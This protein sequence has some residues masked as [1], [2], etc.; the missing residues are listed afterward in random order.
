MG[1]GNSGGEARKDALKI[2]AEQVWSGISVLDSSIYRQSESV[3]NRRRS[4]E[5]EEKVR[6]DVLKSSL[7][8][9]SLKTFGQNTIKNKVNVPAY[10]CKSDVA[11][12]YLD[13]LKSINQRV[14]VQKVNNSFC[15]ALYNTYSP[16][17]MMFE[18][19]LKRLGE[20]GKVKMTDY[21]I[22]EKKCNEMS[23]SMQKGYV[24]F[25][26]AIDRAVAEIV[27]KRGKAQTKI[28]IAEIYAPPDQLS[29][30][31]TDEL[32]NKLVK[33]KNFA[34]MSADMNAI[35]GQRIGPLKDAEAVKV[36]KKANIVLVGRF[37]PYE[38][39]SHFKIEALD[40]QSPPPPKTLAMH[41]DKIR[42]D[43]A[44]LA[45][46]ISGKPPAITED[47]LAYLN[48]GIDLYRKEKYDEAINELS[49]AL[50]INGN[51]AEGYYFR[52][53]AYY[54]KGNYDRAIDD[55]E[56]ALRI[57][58]NN[59]NTKQTLEIARQERGS[60]TSQAPAPSSSA[61]PANA[62]ASG[63]DAFAAALNAAAAQSTAKSG[64][65]TP[66][67]SS[68]RDPRDG[69]TYKTVKIGNQVW[70]AENLNYKVGFF[71]KGK[72]KCYD[73]EESNCN[74]YGVLYDLATAETVCPVG[75]HL[76]T[77]AEWEVLMVAV[78]GYKT[79]GKHLKA[80]SGWDS[81]EG[82]DGNGLDTYGF[83]A[84]PGGY[85]GI[86]GDFGG[87]GSIGQWWT[88]S[89]EYA[90]HGRTMRNSREYGDWYSGYARATLFSVRCVKN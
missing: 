15:E 28:V 3:S 69:K 56:A 72:S 59:A 74:K 14:S 10:V 57:N 82:K 77:K 31:I 20:D 89:G 8:N 87:V 7:D 34:V 12:L 86:H 23:A 63:L 65:A 2:I 90:K 40:A 38:K 55:W 64:S 36:G 44:E 75:W 84:M 88:S 54:E 49:R 47:A 41:T 9:V 83:S 35:D 78:G 26:E 43:E 1:E 52:G 46:L 6:R 13:S 53:L 81:Y 85:G 16:R 45:D 61:T 22:V 48:N 30:F 79:D 62:L 68:F 29:D 58:P 18:S 37:A 67:V 21:E 80:K 17:V 4:S 32:K 51:L 24:G 39:Y 19:V 66:V 71:A 27:S 76:P 25:D 70:M 33:V 5:S 11:R 42:P 60:K 73:N 50:A